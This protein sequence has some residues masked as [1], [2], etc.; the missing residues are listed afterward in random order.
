MRKIGAFV[1]FIST[2]CLVLAGCGGGSKH[3]NT[4]NN[5]STRTLVS[6]SVTGSTASLAAGTTLQLAAEGSYS[7]GTT[8]ILTN[9]ATWTTS[10]S[11]LATA[12]TS[13]LITSY[14]A[15]SVTVTA[16][17]GSV[18]GKM[19]ISV[20]QATL[21]SISVL[22]AGSLA[23]GSTVQLGAQGAYSDKTTQS[24]TNQVTWQSS[25]STVASV[26]TSGLVTA[27]KA[28][29][30]TITAAMNSV[31][32]TA[33]VTVTAAAVVLNA[34]NVG[35]PSPSMAAGG[36]EQLTATGVYSD[37]S[38]QLLTSQ[39]AWSSSDTTVAS[40]SASGVLTG[41]KAGSVTVTATLGT[42]SGIGSVSVS[43]PALSSVT[44]F[45]A[46]FSIASG[47]NKQ[48]SATGFYANG[49]S[50]DVTNQVAWNSQNTASATVSSSG[51]VS[52]VSAGTATITATL[53]SITGTSVA[54]ISTAQLQSIAITPLTASIA[55]GQTQQYMA[56]GIFSDG[57]QSDIT[58]AVTWNSSDTSI[59]TVNATGLATG[60]NAG[61]AAISATSGSVTSATAATLTVTSAVLTEIDIAPDEQ[62]I[63][64]GGQYQLTLTGTYSDNSTQSITGGTWTSSDSTF[65]S[66]DPNTG[67]VTGVAN[68]NNNAI[69]ITASYGGLTNTT[70]VY[71]TSAVPE[72]LQ[73]TPTSASIASGTTLQYAANVV[74][75]DGSIQPVTAGI[76]WTSSAATVAGVDSNGLA[77]GLAPGQATI[78]AAYESMT[79]TALLTVTPAVLTNIVVT[80]ITTVVGINGNVQFTAT[81][82]FSDNS[83]QDL[84]SQAVWTSSSAAF[85]V[86]S[87]DGVASGLSAGTT[88]IT[89]SFGGVSGSATLNVTTAQLIGIAISPDKPIVPP[90]SKIQL[91]AIGTFSDGSQLPLS[92]VSWH[93]SSARFAMINGSGVL[94]TKKSTSKAVTVS[95]TLNGISGQTNI[96]ITSMTLQ[97]LSVKPSTPTIAVGT[98]QGFSLIGTFSDG[99]TQVDLT[100]SARW[101]T[102]NYQFAVINRQGV[103]TAVAQ[104][105]V[106][107]TGTM[108]SLGGPLTT[109]TATLTVSN[110]TLQGITVTPASQTI[111]LGGLQQFAASGLFSDGSTQDITTV[112]TWNSSTP[113]VAVINASGVASSASH[114]QTNINAT[115]KNVT[116]ST[117]LN[118]N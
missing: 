3:S 76:A 68:S 32:G 55:T 14:K 87:A 72:S 95:A 51:L 86:I 75:S 107:I 44:I 118:V 52:G 101:Q 91:T 9:Q 31:S 12:N 11:T 102:S 57:S 28:G 80:P 37:N 2:V 48:L 18:S 59:A 82:V 54:T 53:G 5:G 64:V 24:I 16:I 111:A 29:T 74:Y 73:L 88:T 49:T 58:N 40:V 30:V 8:A 113:T 61:T 100:A 105:V 98:T 97:A 35:T 79:G 50:Q 20:T 10:N 103:A 36:T 6:I 89:A 109:A 116:G 42:I 43:A 15:G 92:G 99:V 117:T 33:G 47:Q 81:G 4:Q 67:I 108:K 13:G 21:S 70:T 85:A 65:A 94:R 23:A 39:V 69:T 17:Q 34:I 41:V 115:F 45:P 22:G 93:T 96:N 78:S 46:A 83:A 104:G 1:G 71:I 84:T 106:V 38:T 7:D 114:G 56:N 19:N 63:P 77:T 62:Y 27:V 112:A 90:H 60:V 25:D 110:A 66:V 26:S